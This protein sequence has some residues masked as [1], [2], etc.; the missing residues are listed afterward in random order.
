M[1]QFQFGEIVLWLKWMILGHF[2]LLCILG[3]IVPGLSQIDIDAPSLPW[4]ILEIS[5][6]CIFVI[7]LAG[8]NDLDF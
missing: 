7:F 5:G 1:K 6:I 4:N 3:Q 8:K 2:V